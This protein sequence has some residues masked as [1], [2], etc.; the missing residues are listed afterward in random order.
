MERVRKRPRA[1]A[2]RRRGDVVTT[3]LRQVFG[4]DALRPGQEAVIH[5]VLAGHP[6][7]AVMPTG[8]GKSLC[9][10]LPAV[11]GKGTTVVVSP[12]IALMK[13]QC[14]KLIELGIA[15]VQINSALPAEAVRDAEQA[16]AD[17]SARFLFTTPEQLT[18]RDLRALLQRA[19]INLFVID[20]AHCISQWGHDFRP[21]YLELHHAIRAI[22]FPTVLALTATAPDAVVQDI[23]DQLRLDDLRIINLGLFRPNLQLAVEPVTG[24]ADKLERVLRVAE[25]H[26]S[27][28]I[29]YCATV[30]HVNAVAASLARAGH[31]VARYHGGLGARVRHEEQE[32]FM[33][34]EVTTMVATNAFGMG[35]DKPDIRVVLH[36]DLPGSLD[37]YYQEAGRAGRDGQFSRAVL[38][39][40]R[41]DR[42]LQRF[43]MAGRHPTVEQFALVA[44]VLRRSSRDGVIT[45]DALQGSTSIAARKLRTIVKAFKDERLVRERRGHGLAI[46]R[47][48]TADAVAEIA[49][50]YEEKTQRDAER[51][52]RMV[53]FAQTALCRWKLLLESLE[54]PPAWQACGMCDNCRGTA[55]RAVGIAAG[56]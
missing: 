2:A 55:H 54:E 43:F 45:L 44:D 5:S 50:D 47:D 23:I 42:R 52:D 41:A 51:L 21:A 14:D 27:P 38:L 36:Y 39:F 24:D 46:T 35:I 7:L 4:L 37:A 6:T 13:D 33:Q 49:A 25:E 28:T 29:V 9:Y 10:Q 17:G 53:M 19:S 32:R 22:G 18:N 30:R 12:L 34:G 40:Q 15:A 20:E 48:L 1:S 8:A 3:A 56:A 11:L 31:A 26:A 16:I